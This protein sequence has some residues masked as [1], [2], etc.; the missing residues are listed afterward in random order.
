MRKSV[1]ALILLVAVLVASNL[2]RHICPARAD[3]PTPSGDV[4]G[5][6]KTDIAD[7]VY[8]LNYLFRSGPPPAPCAAGGDGGVIAF[9]SARDGNDEI[10]TIRADGTNLIRLARD[11]ASDSDPAWSPDGRRLAFVSNRA[12]DP[13]I[14]VMNA[15]GTNVV[16]R[17][18][19][20]N[21]QNPA[22][23]PDGTRLAYSAM[24]N[25]SQNI[26]VVSPDA[27]EPSLLVEKPGWDDQPSWSPDGARVALASD[28]LAYDF[29]QDIYIIN[30]DGSGFTGLTSDI[31]DHVDYVHPQWS[32]D[33]SKLSLTI[34]ETVGIDEY[35][36]HIGVMAS[37][38]SGLKP[39]APAALWTTSSWSPD[40]KKIAFTSDTGGATNIEWVNADGTASGILVENGW[41]P[42]W[43]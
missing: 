42:D 4:N 7:A 40:G 36:V 30:S 11:P 37:D 28:W 12:G 38:G 35:I 32:Q 13:N 3:E 18:F 16:Q 33:G 39:L 23:S 14:Y 26:W 10:Y 6:L 22:W 1:V 43:H 20:G 29:V 34:I 8:L 17:T 41:S 27:G 19:T 24:S 2:G 15:D 9:V 31:F 25:G 5:D 21:G